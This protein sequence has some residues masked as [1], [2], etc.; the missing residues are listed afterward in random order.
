MTSETKTDAQQVPKGEFDSK[1]G[2]KHPP[3]EHQFK[4]GKSGNPKGRPRKSDNSAYLE[5]RVKRL[6]MKVL[7]RPLSLRIGDRVEKM[8]GIEAAIRVLLAEGLKGKTRL[9]LQL[10]ET[11]MDIEAGRRKDKL[12]LMDAAWKYKEEAYRERER[13]KKEGV[14]APELVPDPDDLHIDPTTGTVSA[15]GPITREQKKERDHWLKVKDWC[16]ND[17]KEAKEALKED[18]GNPHE[19]ESLAYSE[20]LLGR[21]ELL[22]S[23]R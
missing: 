6:I 15:T 9:L 3:K 18:P 4:K 11:V 8:S 22:V 21:I 2:Y 12:D 17:I 23:D 16:Q 1:V 7:D 14:P 19:L 20:K 5:E 10:V 13:C